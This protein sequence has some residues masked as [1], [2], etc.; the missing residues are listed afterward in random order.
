MNFP[1]DQEHYDSEFDQITP[2][3]GPYGAPEKAQATAPKPGISKRGKVVFSAASVVLAVGGFAFYQDHQENIAA[4]NAKA[5]EIQLQQAKLDLERLKVTN[6]V[7]EKQAKDQKV[8]AKSLQAKID[9]CV[10]RGRD[11]SAYL[12]GVVDACRSQYA[13]SATVD[14]QNMQE[15]GAASSLPGQGG[16]DASSVLIA[17]IG[18]AVLGA[19]VGARRLTR[20]DPA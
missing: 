16:G 9:A 1:E 6:Q 12:Q 19:A 13:A 4:Q 10:D 2:G 3:L 17:G 8:E 15:A 11:G 20:R 18:A 7:D 5:A 14:G